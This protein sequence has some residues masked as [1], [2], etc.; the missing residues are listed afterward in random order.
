M[1]LKIQRQENERTVLEFTMNSDEFEKEL[2]KAFRKEAK[3]FKVPGFRN[4]KVPRNVIEKMYGVEILYETVINDVANEQYKKAIE[5]NNLEVVSTPVLDVKQIE[6]GK[7]FIFTVAVFEKPEAVVK[8]YKGLEIEKVENKVTKEDVDAKIEAD[9]E[10]NARVEYVSDRPLKEGD[11]STIDFE[12]FV[13]GVP[14][15]GGKAE[16]YELTIGSN[17]FIP[18]FE[19]SMIGM[20]IGEEK[21]INVTFPED[22]HAENLAGKPAVFKVKLHTIKEKIL[23]E[24]DDEF[25]KDISEF[26][27]LEEYRKSVEERLQKEKDNLSKSQKEQKVL[28]KLIENTEVFIPEE[29]LDDEVESILDGYRANLSHQGLSLE[30]FCKY[31]NK[32][33]SD[34]QEETK[35]EAKRNVTIRLALEAVA[36]QED[37]KVENSEIDEKITE[38]INSYGTNETSSNLNQNENVRK[39]MKKNIKNQKIIDLIIDSAIEK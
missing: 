3:H 36:K 2:D 28:D 8:K 9:R 32:T 37:I 30:Q 10:K 31:M 27:T 4:G 14:F 6:R 5:E 1:E 34:L 20:N 21:D 26:D 24:L 39:Y 35:P 22:Y 16:D 18:G 38:L 19:E 12:G 17:Q 15:E 7:E 29:M 33:V 25:A 13:D 11:I 23:P